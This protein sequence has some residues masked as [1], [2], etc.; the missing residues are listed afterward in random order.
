MLTWRKQAANTTKKTQKYCAAP[1]T[2]KT[3]EDVAGVRRMR[4]P[5]DG[6]SNCAVATSSDPFNG[7][8]AK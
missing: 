1:T 4:R 3:L 8:Y 5:F 2:S 7:D 6:E